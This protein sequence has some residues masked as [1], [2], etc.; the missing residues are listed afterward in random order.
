MKLHLMTWNSNM[1]QEK[2]DSINEERYNSIVNIVKGR[3]ELE[4]S[5][6]VLQEIPY[7]SNNGW[8]EHPIWSKLKKDF[9]ESE[10]EIFY[11]ESNQFQIMMSIIIS[12]KDVFKR[13][14]ETNINDNRIVVCKKD[15]VIFVGVHMPTDFETIT[16]ENKWKEQEWDKLINFV[17][18]QNEKNRKTIILGDFNAYIECTKKATEKKFKQLHQLA[19]DIIP[20]DTPTFQA[21]TAIDHIFVNFN[22]ELNYQYHIG[23]NNYNLSD[24]KYITLELEIES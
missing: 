14:E 13:F 19:K 20:D 1:Y 15:E 12:K 6:V 22:T 17:T 2:I 4:N 24:H 21:G 9:P 8:K 5:M 16:E 18:K 3:L 23:N 10:Y 11:S 7:K